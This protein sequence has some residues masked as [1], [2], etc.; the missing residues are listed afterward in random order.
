MVWL[1]DPPGQQPAGSL[2][3]TAITVENVPGEWDLWTGTVNR[4]PIVNYVR[5]EGEDTLEIEFD[6]MDFLRDARNRGL[7]L[8]GSQILSVAVGFEIWNGPVSN[9]ETVDF[10]VHVN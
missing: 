3:E 9:L 2:T 6:V 10:Y 5:A 7:D 4:S 8:P 1:R